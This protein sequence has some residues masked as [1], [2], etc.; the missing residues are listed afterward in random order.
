M[1]RRLADIQILLQVVESKADCAGIKNKDLLQAFLGTPGG[2]YAEVE[3][4]DY[5]LS[6]CLA[7]GF[8]AAV[9]LTN[10]MDPGVQLTWKGHDYLEANS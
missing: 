10:N 8:L 3:Q 4:V 1:K 5:A 2:Q 9:K 6:L 7:E